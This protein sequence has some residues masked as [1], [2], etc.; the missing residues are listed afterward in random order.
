VD[1]SLVSR[2]KSMDLWLDLEGVKKGQVHLKL[3]WLGFTENPV[4]LK[5]SL[6][7]AQNHGLAS[8]MLTVKLDS[9]KN[10]PVCSSHNFTCILGT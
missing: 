1:L 6:V 10:L 2:E 4:D 9:A 8:C 3:E 5:E 7:D